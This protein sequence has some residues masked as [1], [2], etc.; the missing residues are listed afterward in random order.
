MPMAIARNTNMLANI[1]IRV[2]SSG[3]LF[4]VSSLK[5]LVDIVSN[6]YRYNR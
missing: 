1:A 3:R 2:V 4:F 5:N 6:R